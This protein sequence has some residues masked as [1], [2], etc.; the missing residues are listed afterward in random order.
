MSDK[1]LGR[2]FW[3]G[4]PAL[5]RGKIQAFTKLSQLACS[6]AK[7]IAGHKIIQ[8]TDYRGWSILFCCVGS[9][10]LKMQI[11]CSGKLTAVWP[12]CPHAASQRVCCLRHPGPGGL[13]REE[14]QKWG[15]DH[16]R[17]ERERQSVWASHIRQIPDA[18]TAD[19]TRESTV[20][21]GTA[22]F[23]S[24]FYKKIKKKN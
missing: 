7:S 22:V 21:R 12:P 4:S 18:A 11:S 10:C 8:L 19:E 3:E 14:G 16:W 5:A 6:T 9:C 24:A 23:R 17:G 20:L 13:H 2:Y 15:W 1:R